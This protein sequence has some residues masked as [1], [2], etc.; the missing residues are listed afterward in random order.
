MLNETINIDLPYKELGIEQNGSATITTYIKD[1]FPKDQDPFKRPLIVICPGGGYNHHSPREGE[2]IA[3]K[4]LDMGYN[5]VVLR[6]SLAP[7][8]YPAQLFEAAYTMKYVRDMQQNGMLMPTKSLS[9]GFQQEVMLPDFL[10]RDGIQKDLIIFWKMYFTAVM[11]ML[12]LMA[13]C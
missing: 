3:I 2:A 12:S 5:A 4:M 10:E 8:T 6:Y 13:C 11:S 1:I 9:Q 7:V